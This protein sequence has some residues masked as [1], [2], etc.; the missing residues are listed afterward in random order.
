LKYTASLN[1]LDNKKEHKKIKTASI[2]KAKHGKI[3]KVTIKIEKKVMFLK[4]IHRFL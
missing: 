3:E 4:T 2:K 1:Q